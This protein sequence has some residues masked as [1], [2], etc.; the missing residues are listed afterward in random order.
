MARR[1]Q[2]SGT[3]RQSGNRVSH[4]K[5]RTKHLFQPNLQVKRVYIPEEKRY[6][7]LKISTRV[8]RTI[9]KFGLQAT[10]KKYGMSLSDLA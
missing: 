1:C 8:I 10:L 5:N 2:I 6:V 9:D 4:A 7:T 3:S